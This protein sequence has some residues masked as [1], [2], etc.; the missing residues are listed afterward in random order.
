M[1]VPEHP[2]AAMALEEIQ[3]WGELLRHSWSASRGLD[4]NS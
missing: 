2:R 3:R 4:F 1:A